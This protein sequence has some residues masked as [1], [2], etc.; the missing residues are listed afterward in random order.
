[1]GRRPPGT[2]RCRDIAVDT[3]TPDVL[4]P[5][6]RPPPRP[7]HGKS[8]LH[9][10]GAFVLSQCLHLVSIVCNVSVGK[11]GG[12]SGAC[13][14]ARKHRP[15]GL[16]PAAGPFPLCISPFA[17]CTWLFLGRSSSR[18]IPGD[19]RGVSR[20]RRY[21]RRFLAAKPSQNGR[22]VPTCRQETPTS[23]GLRHHAFLSPYHFL[24]G[25]SALNVPRLALNKWAMGV[26]AKGVLAACPPCT[27]D[28][29]HRHLVY[30]SQSRV[31][32][33]LDYLVSGLV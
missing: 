21:L 27:D 15:D 2:P 17:W 30:T 24:L 18:A 22:A 4:M 26:S 28:F 1:M 16:R 12:L 33:V 13:Y 14:S 20:C 10:L 9:C 29:H 5:S 3:L 8:P 23:G 11:R 25:G 6:S 7:R 19:S 31:F 32:S